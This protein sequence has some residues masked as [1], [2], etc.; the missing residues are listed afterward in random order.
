VEK[1]RGEVVGP[2]GDGL[3]HQPVPEG[4][5][6]HASDQI[7]GGSGRGTVVAV[8]VCLELVQQ[9]HDDRLLD[10]FLHVGFLSGSRVTGRR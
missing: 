1:P 4:G 6:G 9:H 7:E 3:I 8:D 10:G 2:D 5:A